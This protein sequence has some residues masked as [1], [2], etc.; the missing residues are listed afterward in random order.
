MVRLNESSK[1]RGVA[2]IAHQVR[3]YGAIKV[4]IPSFVKLLKDDDRLVRSAA[5]G[6]LDKFAV[7]GESQ[8]CTIRTPFDRMQSRAPR[9]AGGGHF[10]ARSTP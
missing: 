5:I 4:A 2:K 1:L 7:H 3:N 6:A 8:L 10:T 9:E